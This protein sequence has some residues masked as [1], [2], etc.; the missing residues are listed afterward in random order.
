MSNNLWLYDTTKQFTIILQL[1]CGIVA[2]TY[3]CDF[4]KHAE[5]AYWRSGVVVVG[6]GWWRHD[7]TFLGG[8]VHSGRSSPAGRA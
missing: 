4:S 5:Y 3:F 7:V 6:D 8:S 2:T 1:K